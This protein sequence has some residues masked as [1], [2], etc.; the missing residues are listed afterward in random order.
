MI[1]S[2]EKP[3]VLILKFDISTLKSRSGLIFK[4]ME[5]IVPSICEISS[6]G[7]KPSEI[8]VANALK[9]PSQF[10]SRRPILKS[11]RP[12]FRLNIPVMA[13]RP[14][15]IGEITAENILPLKR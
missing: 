5:P 6:E 2:N 13:G 14:N 15:E 3:S 1:S 4:L 11:N 10:R 9:N 7:S 8:F 12:R